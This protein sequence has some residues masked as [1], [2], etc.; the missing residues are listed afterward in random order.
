VEEYVQE[1]IR[2][3]PNFLQIKMV[4][5]CGFDIWDFSLILVVCTNANSFQYQKDLRL[6]KVRQTGRILLSH[7]GFVE[8]QNKQ[9]SLLISS[10]L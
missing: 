4:G 9:G 1:G 5:K 7:L 3:S 6:E 10:I 8:C 2:L